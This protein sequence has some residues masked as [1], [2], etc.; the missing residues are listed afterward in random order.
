MAPMKRPAS[1]SSSGASKRQAVDPAVAGC[2]LVSTAL[3][4]APGLKEMVGDLV[5]GSLGVAKDARL[6]NQAAVV[7]MIGEALTGLQGSL[8]KSLSAAQAKLNGA[9]A[10]KAAR[11]AAVVTVTTALA[12]LEATVAECK[13]ALGTDTAALKEAADALKKVEAAQKEGDKGVEA[14]AAKKAALEAALAEVYGP[15]K[16]KAAS[17]AEVKKL[18]AVGKE[19]SFDASLL[20]TLPASLKKASEARGH[21]DNITLEQLDGEFSK[22]S[23]ELAKEVEAGQPGKAERAAT[24]EAASSAHAAA[25]AKKDASAAALDAAKLALKKGVADCSAAEKAVANFYPDLKVAA[26][27]LDT[28]KA[29]LDGFNAGALKSFAELSERVTPPPEPVAPPAA[30][31]APA[32]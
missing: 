18:V 26:D 30:E 8:T 5:L 23:A 1:A 16:A 19:F 2:G 32:V 10:D 31:P 28:A 3:E 9:D 12:G 7:K 17:N 25:L 22:C 4:G 13:T 6:P 21:F 14:V 24:T 20:A 27:A 29:D 11:E 15:L